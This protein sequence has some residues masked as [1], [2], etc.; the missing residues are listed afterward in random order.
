[1]TLLGISGQKYRSRRQAIRRSKEG[2]GKGKARGRM[3]NPP[4]KKSFPN[5]HCFSSKEL[6]KPKALPGEKKAA[7]RKDFVSSSIE[8]RYVFV[9]ILLYT[10]G[11]PTTRLQLGRPL[12]RK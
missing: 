7:S 10:P 6:G 4:Q 12:G 8:P 11:I 9:L 1:M 3:R 5:T 2:E